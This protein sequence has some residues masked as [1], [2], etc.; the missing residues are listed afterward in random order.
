M[1]LEIEVAAPSAM[2]IA[3]KP[4]LTR[5]SSRRCFPLVVSISKAGHGVHTSGDSSPDNV[6][7]P[8]FDRTIGIH[9]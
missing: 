2:A 3:Q 6:T 8:H 7:L 5:L 4:Q 9:L 1:A